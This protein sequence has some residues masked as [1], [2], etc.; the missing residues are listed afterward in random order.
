MNDTQ[1]VLWFIGMA[2]AIALILGLGTLTMA[3]VLKKQPHHSASEAE[4]HTHPRHAKDS[5]RHH[6]YDRFH[7]AA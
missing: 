6:W 4:V 1:Y 7:H 2:F 5:E 3:G